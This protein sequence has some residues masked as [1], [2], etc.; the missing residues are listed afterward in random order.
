MVC[1]GSGESLQLECKPRHR[2]D[3][4]RFASIQLFLDTRY[5]IRKK[6]RSLKINTTIV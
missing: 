4:E 3:S 6:L 5:F 1:A 2:Y